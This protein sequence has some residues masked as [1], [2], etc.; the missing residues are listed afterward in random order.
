MKKAL[1]KMYE[2]RCTILNTEKYTKSNGATAY[3]YKE[4]C[5][6][7]PCRLSF[8]AASTADPTESG[9]TALV[10]SV[11]LFLSPDVKVKEGSK[12]TVTQNGITKTFK[13][14]GTPSIYESHQEI[15]LELDKDYS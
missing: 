15:M 14:S 5:K 1:E 3:K 7:Q 13:L 8:S 11:K 9:A 4:V 2:G 10:Q 12:I 6:D